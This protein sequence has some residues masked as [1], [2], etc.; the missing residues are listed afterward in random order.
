M[1]DPIRPSETCSLGAIM[2]ALLLL[3]GCEHGTGASTASKS[4]PPLDVKITH[5][6]RGE[7]TRSITL[8]GEIK[9]Y[10]A[11]TLYAKVSGYL[12]TISVDKGD[13]VKEG[14]LLA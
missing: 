8:P 6:S 12:K 14:A 13:E 2:L 1:S 10:Q 5:P 3:C 9:P 7:I 11:A 4:E